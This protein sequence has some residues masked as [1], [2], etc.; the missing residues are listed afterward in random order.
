MAKASIN[1]QMVA[2]MKAITRMIKSMAMESTRI[3]MADP[4]RA[5]GKMVS[6]TVRESLSRRK[7]TKDVAFGR[8]V[9]GS[10]GFRTTRNQLVIE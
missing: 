1:G 5:S 7:V 9:R 3:Q 2:F 10:N 6:S 4:T 8:R